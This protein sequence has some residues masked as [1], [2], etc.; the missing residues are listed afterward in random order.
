[1]VILHAYF[2]LLVCGIDECVFHIMWV[3]EVFVADVVDFVIPPA[4]SSL[5]AT[6]A[7]CHLRMYP[8]PCGVGHSYLNA[9]VRFLDFFFVWFSDLLCGFRYFECGCLIYGLWFPDF[10]FQRGS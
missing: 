3:C 6:D 5:C 9:G 2:L 7:C 10:C 1:M 4:G 8:C